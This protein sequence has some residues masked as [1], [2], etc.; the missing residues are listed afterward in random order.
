MNI[1]VIGGTGFVGRYFLRFTK[2]KNIIFTSSR[3]KAGFI[4]FDIL[5]DNIIPLINKYKINR[6]VFL[7]AISNPDDCEKD[8]KNSNLI[9]VQKT[10]EIL[11]ILLKKKIYFIFFSSEY[12]FDGQY[13]N[14][15][16]NS[17]AKTKLL[18]GRQKLKIE[19]FLKNNKKNTFSIL[20]ISKTFGDDLYDGSVFTRFI[21]E[22]KKNYFFNV[23]NDQYFSA[24][25][26]KDLV[27]IIE[28]FLFK[29]ICGLYNVCG[30][31]QLSRYEYFTKIKKIFN[32]NKVILNR[33]KLYN[34]TPNK[35]I[36]LNVT[37]NNKKI[38]KKI[39]FKFTKFTKII[40]KL[41]ADLKIKNY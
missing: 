10:R 15:T 14:Y 1:L 33:E 11:K 20:R 4:K 3:K 41:K 40:R 37:M 17:L 18:Y 12:V 27:K 22:T 16:E 38:K 39:K 7:S 19:K 26:V 32:F 5:K 25:Y 23:A 29:K 28:I 2:L 9:N 21:I 8:I 34:L 30:D 35:N 31:E 36:P 13:G 24:L 6:I